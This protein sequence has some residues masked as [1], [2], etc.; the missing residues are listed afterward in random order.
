VSFLKQAIKDKKKNRTLIFFIIVC[1][2]VFF[3]SDISLSAQNEFRKDTPLHVT[4]DSMI[5]RKKSSTI[6]FKGNV[7]VTKDDSIIHA[8]SIT[9]FFTRENGKKKE[10][11]KKIKK[12][13]ARGNVKYSS[14]TRK[15]YAG[16][17]VYTYDTEILVLTGNSPKVITTD[18]NSV[19]GEKI[20]LFQK[21]G[22]V[23]IEG[24][25]NAVFIP[26]KKNKE[27]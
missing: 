21:D 5:A 25:V 23:T 8:D 9:M 12:I 19:T 1:S 22:R 2:A 27:E 6:E 20:T 17:A 24:G 15:A 26:E 7:V 14:G 11:K 13:V 3:L 10:T 18:G 16:Q 4:S